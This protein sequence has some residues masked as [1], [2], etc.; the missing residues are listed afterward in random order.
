MKLDGLDK[1]NSSLI[2]ILKVNQWKNTQNV[3]EWVTKIEEKRNHKFIVFNI[4]DF[5]PPIKD[6]TYQSNK[7]CRKTCKHNKRS[8]RNYKTRKEISFV[9]Q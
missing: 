7:L 8:Q 1:I 6:T 3:I 2:E 9:R 5:Y 4:K